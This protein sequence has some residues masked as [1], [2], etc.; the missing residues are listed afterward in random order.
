MASVKKPL[1]LGEGVK[2]LADNLK[3]RDF[4]IWLRSALARSNGNNLLVT[5]V[6]QKIIGNLF[7]EPS[8][9]QE[10]FSAKTMMVFKSEY[11]TK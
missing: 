4:A 7:Y 2:L 8:H 1:P 10:K 3:E 11:T 6:T 9:V 5:P